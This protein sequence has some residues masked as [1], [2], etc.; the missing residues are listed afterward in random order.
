MKPI[1][2]IDVHCLPPKGSGPDLDGAPVIRRKSITRLLDFAQKLGRA[3]LAHILTFPKST[4]VKYLRPNTF[5][6]VAQCQD[7]TKI[8]QQLGDS[9]NL[10]CFQTSIRWR[11]FSANWPRPIS[12]CR[13]KVCFIPIQVMSQHLRHKEEIEFLAFTQLYIRMALERLVKPGRAAPHGTNSQKSRRIPIAKALLV[14]QTIL[15]F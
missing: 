1:K 11:D 4:L 12:I 6:R 15:S 10:P 5:N 2:K 13:C 14:R 8:R 9:I 7:D 3:N